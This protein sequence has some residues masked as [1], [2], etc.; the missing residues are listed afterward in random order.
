MKPT[1]SLGRFA[2]V[3]GVTGILLLASLALPTP[4]AWLALVAAVAAGTGGAAALVQP[5][6]W[7]WPPASAIPHLAL[8]GLLLFAAGLALHTYTIAPTLLMLLAVL[9]ALLVFGILIVGKNLVLVH[10]EGYTGSLGEMLNIATYLTAFLLF[11]TVYRLAPPAPLKLGL[12]AVI[13]VL[14][15]LELLTHVAMTNRR[16]WVLSLVVGGT[17][18]ET[19]W[20]LHQ[21]PQEGA[22]TAMFL[23]LGY[24]LITGL[25][26]SHFR[27]RLNSWV[28]LEFIG[29]GVVSFV[30]LFAFQAWRLG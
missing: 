1:I 6:L 18:A 17:L 12:I 9:L 13:G 5:P 7:E 22:Y 8:P 30:F 21:W 25:L 16:R 27:H 29:V 20:S 14:L 3:L 10:N 28:V 23:L 24:Y 2:A 26:Q 11:I 19:A 4:W 15:T